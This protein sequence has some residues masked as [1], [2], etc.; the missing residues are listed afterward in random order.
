MF[1]NSQ[2][3]VLTLGTTTSMPNI[4]AENVIIKEKPTAISHNLKFFVSILKSLVI[5]ICDF[6]DENN[7]SLPYVVLV[8]INLRAKKNKFCEWKC[9]S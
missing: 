8:S 5:N 9:H 6:F 2:D 4:V 1:N 7:P 3:I